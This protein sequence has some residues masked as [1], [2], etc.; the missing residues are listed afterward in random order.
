MKKFVTYLLGT[1][2]IVNSGICEDQ[3]FLLQAS[4]GEGVIEGQ[5]NGDIEIVQGGVLVAKEVSPF[6]LPTTIIVDIPLELTDIPEGTIFEI[7][8]D[9]SLTY[10]PS[11]PEDTI[12][13][14]DAGKYSIEIISSEYLTKKVIID[15][16]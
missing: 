2:V 4:S 16:S 1:G 12:T 9:N 6:N 14:K 11:T 5:G 7:S 15:A 8:G 13:F 10:I 3:D